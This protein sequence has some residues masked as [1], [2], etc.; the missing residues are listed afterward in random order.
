MY[1]FYSFYLFNYLFPPPRMILLESF[2]RILSGRCILYIVSVQ[3]LYK[4]N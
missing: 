3:I 4:V 2:N 1:T